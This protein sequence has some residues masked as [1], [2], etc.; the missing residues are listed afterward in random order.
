V[1]LRIVAG[2]VLMLCVVQALRFEASNPPVEGDVHAPSGIDTALRSACY[3]CHSDETRWPW[4]ASL[5]PI[6][7]LVHR[8]VSE[9]RRRLNFSRWSAY[10]ADPGTRSE[11]LDHIRQRLLRG[12]MPP[13]HYTALHPSARW[14]ALQR[15]EVRRWVDAELT[16]STATP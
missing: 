13:W 14:T 9:G 3:D 1:R 16:E 7:W 8:D 4:Y 12:D 6:S 2:V 15:E 10:A 11:K 5:A